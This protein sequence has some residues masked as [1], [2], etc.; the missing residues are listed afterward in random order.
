MSHTSPVF[1]RQGKNS[2]VYF[3]FEKPKNLVIFVHGFNGHATDT[4]NNFPKLIRENNDFNQSDIIFYG[5]DS[6]KGQVNNM[7]LS[8]YR[9]LIQF[10]ENSP[11]S[12]GYKREVIDYCF[13]YN[14]IIIVGHSLGALVI[15]KALLFAKK[16]NKNWLNLTKMIL[17]A[18]AHKGA[19]IQNLISNSLPFIG[20]LIAN[21]G[22]FFYPVLNDLAPNSN[23]ISNIL[24][25]T[26]NYINA[27]DG[28]FTISHQVIWA[29]NE[30]IVV[31]E[32]FTDIEPTPISFEKGT[33]HMEVCKP[34]IDFID[35]YHIVAQAII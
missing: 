1:I 30:L 14:N 33:N 2:N 11:N 7:G 29:D 23:T 6:L 12:L 15:R 4:W 18:P 31:N 10:I 13:K 26:N 17:F 28:D 16:D 20:Q 22:Y 5:Y 34:N 21:F 27:N 25:Q 9:A 8:F 19:R 32:E 35:P 3:S 24:S